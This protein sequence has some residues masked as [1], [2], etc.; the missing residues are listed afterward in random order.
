[1][2][3]QEG[4]PGRNSRRN[5]R[6]GQPMQENRIAEIEQALFPLSRIPLQE[7]LGILPF[8]EKT[9]A[10]RKPP[11]LASS[12]IG[13]YEFSAFPENKANLLDT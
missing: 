1:M 7:R 3:I 6:V 10:D 5:A 2:G 11:A 8:L 4:L 12:R 13:F 9:V